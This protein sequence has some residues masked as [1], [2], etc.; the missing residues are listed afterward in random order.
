MRRADEDIHHEPDL[1]EPEIQYMLDQPMFQY[2]LCSKD[3]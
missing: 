3:L 2:Q 1:T